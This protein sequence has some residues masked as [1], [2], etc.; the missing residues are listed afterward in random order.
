LYVHDRCS[1]ANFPQ[2]TRKGRARF[3]QSAGTLSKPIKVGKTANRLVNA[4]TTFV[5][6]QATVG[7]ATLCRTLE[8]SA[9]EASAFAPKT[10]IAAS[11]TCGAIQAQIGVFPRKNAIPFC[12]D[13]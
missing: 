11:H 2:M 4:V 7:T 12:G 13:G 1:V 6:Q 5:Y 3:K 8:I 9:H 10:D